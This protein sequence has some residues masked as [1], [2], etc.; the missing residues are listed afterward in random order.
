VQ[1]PQ[2][3]C[4]LLTGKNLRLATSAETCAAK[5]ESNP[6]C[7]EKPVTSEPAGA[8]CAGYATAWCTKVFDCGFP[9]FGY[10]DI[11]TCNKVVTDA[12]DIAHKAPGSTPVTAACNASI[13]ALSCEGFGHGENF[14]GAKC[15]AGTLPDASPCQFGEQCISQMCDMAAPATSACGTCAPQRNPID[16]PCRNSTDCD[17]GL[18]C[19]AAKKCANV[20]IVAAGGDC[21]APGTRC[22]V[23]S[24]CYL[25]TCEARLAPGARCSAGGECD[26]EGGYECLPSGSPNATCTKVVPSKQVGATCNSVDLLCDYGLYCKTDSTTTSQGTCQADLA[27]GSPCTSGDTCAGTAR[28]INNVCTAF[29]PL[30][31]NKP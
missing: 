15:F 12:C 28:C 7:A 31:C 11:T 3:V 16:G 25:S 10:H 18:E 26:F 30:L 23:R 2:F 27:V 4:T 14:F 9:V 8:G 13:N 5:E 17:F 6:I 24:K 21:S 22:T 1:L 19:S 29:D 20:I